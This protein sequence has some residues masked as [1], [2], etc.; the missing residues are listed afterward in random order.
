MSANKPTNFDELYEF[1]RELAKVNPW[2]TTTFGGYTEK[3]NPIQR[4]MDQLELEES[5][6]RAAAEMGWAVPE[7]VFE[8][9]GQS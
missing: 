4:Q 8:S 6:R 2:P 3:G 1:H 9:D 7:A 5:V